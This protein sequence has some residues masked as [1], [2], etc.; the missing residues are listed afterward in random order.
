MTHPFWLFDST[1]NLSGT[2]TITE[3]LV[4]SKDGNGFAGTSTEDTFDLKGKQ[5]SH[6]SAQ[7]E[8]VRI[9]P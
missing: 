8:G 1:G 9:R 7:V 2:G 3:T 5:L 4:L 6:D